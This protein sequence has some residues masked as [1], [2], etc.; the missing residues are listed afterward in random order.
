MSDRGK[1]LAADEHFL[2]PFLA[3]ALRATP[4]AP[5]RV[6]HLAQVIHFPN[7]GNDDS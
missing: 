6:S 4:P 2:Y 3:D 7:A 5:F 1:V